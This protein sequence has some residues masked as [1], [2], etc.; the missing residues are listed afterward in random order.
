MAPTESSPNQSSSVP[1]SPKGDD[2]LEETQPETTKI[3][4]ADPSVTE[5]LQSTVSKWDKLSDPSTEEALR[6]ANQVKVISLYLY[7]PQLTA[8]LILPVTGPTTKDRIILPFTRGNSSRV[9][10]R[11]WPGRIGERVIL[12]GGLGHWTRSRKQ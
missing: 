8:D 1:K 6:E 2:K 12:C 4:L 10:C 5:I 9:G 7:S 11:D 3:H